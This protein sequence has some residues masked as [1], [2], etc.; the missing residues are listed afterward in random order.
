MA[1]ERYEESILEF[2]VSAL[3]ARVG[4]PK[5][6]TGQGKLA[7][8][9]IKKN[10]GGGTCVASSSVEYA[11]PSGHKLSHVSDILIARPGGK[12]LVVELQWA[13]DLSDQLKARAYDILHLKQALGK[14][15]TAFLI[16]L[17]AGLGGLSAEQA[18]EICYPFDQFIALEHQ[19]PQNPAIWVP[20]LDR[21]EAE[22]AER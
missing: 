7:H 21:I 18:R 13:T 16:Y 8:F 19:D 6:L 22:I 10:L 14:N 9:E 5:T 11:L 20:V 3:F 12:N 15:L 1:T 17:R 2:L 4:E